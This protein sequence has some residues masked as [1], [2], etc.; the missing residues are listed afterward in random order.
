MSIDTDSIDIGTSVATVNIDATT[1]ATSY[2]TGALVV[3]GGVGIAGNLY[4]QG[5][6][7]GASVTFTSINGTPIGNTT[8]NS[9]AFTSLQVDNINIDGNIISS[10]NNNGDIS[11]LPN[12]SGKT[13]LKNTYIGDEFTSLQEYI[14]D[15]TAGAV[16]AG[17]GIDVTYDDTAGTVTIDAELA[18]TTNK[19]VASFDVND[20]T[21]TLGAVELVD[22]V[23]KSITTD[24]G[25]LVPSTHTFEIRGGE[26]IDV[27]HATNVITVT[28][29][30]ATTT[31]IGVASF[32]SASFDV[33]EGAVTIKTA[34]VSNTQLA[35]SSITIG[36]TN[37]A[38][39]ATSTSLGGVTQLDVDNIRINGNEIMSTDTNG[40]IVL[41]PNG[42]GAI[43]AST[44]RIKNL[45]EPQFP[46]DAATK[47]Y[48]DT[49]AE[50]LH[51]HEA[52]HVAT[53][54]SL[55]TIT[56]GTVAY[57]NGT[58]GVG[59]FLTLSV[60]VTT[61]DGHP[62]T[63]GDRILVKNQTPAARNGIY[64]WATGGTILTRATDFDTGAEIAG[65]DFVFVENGNLYN[66]T[67]WVQ[68]EEVVAVGTDPLV[69]QQFAG[70]GTYTAGSGLALVGNEFSLN[71]SLTG[72]LGVIGDQLQILSTTAGNGLT[73][74]SGVYDV[75]GTTDRITANANSIDIA[76]TYVGQTSITTL[77]TITTGTWNGNPIGPA[78]GGLGLS[79]ISANQLI[80]GA[81]GNTYTTL[82]M[83]TAGQV[84]QVNSAGTALVYGDI[85]G[86][87][88]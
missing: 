43:D 78:Y 46:Q 74:T 17:E 62:L 66:N 80:V 60:A 75:V 18:T 36:T 42:T 61:I 19:G 45:A 86:G 6:I 30:L 59:A 55:E 58:D 64:T 4:V 23:V 54:A 25:A 37:V 34:G 13:I 85:D 31:N 32:S 77:G 53:Q 40:D 27:T 10:T 76:S 52:C 51:I 69:W 57:N 63:N 2:T 24:S 84:L 50:G 70:A 29:E 20:F 41:N 28:G 83:G 12:G 71:V 1:Q 56:G 15:A 47:N 8:P 68:T 73:F 49:L 81:A 79:S 35:N 87:T 44:A 22:R 38:L 72:G 11:I 26:G 16:I 88:Y 82:S 33:T 3:D 48:V 39:G 5:S 21:V 14:Q 7:Q 65:G 67:G 9:G